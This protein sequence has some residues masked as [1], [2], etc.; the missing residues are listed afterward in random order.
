MRHD[1]TSEEPSTHI[2]ERH[3]VDLA[4]LRKLAARE[5]KAEQKGTLVAASLAVERIETSDIQRPLC[6]SRSYVQRWACAYRDGGIEAVKEGPRG[7]SVCKITGEKL[8]TLR[9][10]IDAGP[11]AKDR[12]CTLRGRDIQCIARD[13]LGV[14]ISLNGV[15]RTLRRMG[16]SC[17]GAVAGPEEAAA[18]SQ[19]SSS[20]KSSAPSGTS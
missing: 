7:G 14:E 16:Y 15:Y 18:P 3:R 20:S 2:T 11:T 6:R 10:R 9:F 13:E 19:T 1:A 4:R 5:K 12:V 8:E 17:L